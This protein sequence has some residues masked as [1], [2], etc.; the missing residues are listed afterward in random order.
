MAF[1][2]SHSRIDLEG[3]R[4]LGYKGDVFNLFSVLDDVGMPG[5]L[6]AW[7]LLPRSTVG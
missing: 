1:V 3:L 2:C 7:E 6:E 4:E 5:L